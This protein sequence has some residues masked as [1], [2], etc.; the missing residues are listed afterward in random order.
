MAT[1]LQQ[2]IAFYGPPKQMP[3]IQ[4]VY[5]LL[6]SFVAT[7]AYSIYPHCLLAYSSIFEEWAMGYDL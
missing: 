6:S 4:A 5:C 1:I 7:T 2:N 3:E